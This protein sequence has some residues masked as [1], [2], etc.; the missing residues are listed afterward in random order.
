MQQSD[1]VGPPPCG[2]DPVIPGDT[3]K[4]FSNNEKISIVGSDSAFIGGDSLSNV[5]SQTREQATKSEHSHKTEMEVREKH[6]K[7]ARAKA[8]R[9]IREKVDKGDKL[10]DI[11]S[12]KEQMSKTVPIEKEKSQKIKMEREIKQ[13]E[14]RY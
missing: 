8:D 2:D 1:P 5:F 13:L 10:L 12:K 7:E 4:V 6:V 14:E 11:R 3:Q 9:E